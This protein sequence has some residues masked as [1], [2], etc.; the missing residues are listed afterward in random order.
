MT[1]GE[2]LDRTLPVSPAQVRSGMMDVRR[3]MPLGMAPW[4]AAGWL[5][6]VLS[7]GSGMTPGAV[8]AQDQARP[9]VPP[10]APAICNAIYAAT[11]KRIRELPIKL[12]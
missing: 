11:G 12:R 9:P 10:V 8:E 2:V 3:R 1:D 7:M 6:A 4:A 5:G